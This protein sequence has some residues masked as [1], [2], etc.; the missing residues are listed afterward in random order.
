[1]K[2]NKKFYSNQTDK[3]ALIIVPEILKHI[4]PETVLDIGCGVGHWLKVFK[5]YGIESIKG[6]DGNYVPDN[7]LVISKKDFVRRDLKEGLSLQQ[8]QYDLILC[9]EVMEHLPNEQSEQIIKRLTELSPVVVFSAAIPGQGGTHHIN[10]Q[11]QS[12]WSN[13]FKRY[14]YIRIDCL[15]KELWDQDIEFCYKQNIF[16]Y[17][18]SKLISKY[19]D[20]EFHITSTEYVPCDIV[21]PQL[22]RHENIR[23]IPLKR[24]LGTILFLPRIILNSRRRKHSESSCISSDNNI[25]SP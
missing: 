19:P 8:P 9:L 22:Y 18:D 6:I 16:F 12:Y 10:E 2:Y 7:E 17:V 5:R 1:M 14:G 4:K 21:H 11:W 15:R 24:A 23:S 3:N 25:Q 20:L 13:L